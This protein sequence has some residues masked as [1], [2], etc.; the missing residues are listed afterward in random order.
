M[1]ECGCPIKT[2]CRAY[3]DVDQIQENK[4]FDHLADIRG[5]NQPRDWTVVLTPRPKTTARSDTSRGSLKMALLLLINNSLSSRQ[6][7]RRLCD[8]FALMACPL[9]FEA[10]RLTLAFAAGDRRRAVGT[11]A[12]DF[13]ECH[14]ALDGCRE[15]ATMTMPEMQHVRDNGEQGS[16]LAAVLSG[17][18]CKCATDFAVERAFHP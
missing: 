6:F 17:R 14:F 8:E 5:A 1:P 4:G 12:D 10:A 18:R 11:A 16:F 9:E 13:I 7:V 15:A 2:W 3:R